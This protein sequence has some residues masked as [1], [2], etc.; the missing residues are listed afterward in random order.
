[1]CSFFLANCEAYLVVVKCCGAATAFFAMRKSDAMRKT[2]HRTQNPDS[3]FI[4]TPFPSLSVLVF[5]LYERNR[6][7]TT[8]EGATKGGFTEYKMGCSLLILSLDSQTAYKKEKNTRKFV[9][10]ISWCAESRLQLFSWGNLTDFGP[11]QDFDPV[12]DN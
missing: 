1:M 7:D 8:F 12:G 6:C 2:G 11:T 9:I 3:P 4:Y 5:L 10:V